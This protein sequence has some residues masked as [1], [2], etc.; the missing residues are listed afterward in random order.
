MTTIVKR[1]INI[2]GHKTSI[3]LEDTF[4]KGLREIASAK[5][6]TLSAL[7]AS[8]DKNRRHRNLS[9]CLRLFVL[10]YYQVQAGSQSAVEQT[11]PSTIAIP[12]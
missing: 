11:E 8:V 1:S 2:A 7:V 3:S 6:L 9:S 5:A 12:K 10:E 4:W